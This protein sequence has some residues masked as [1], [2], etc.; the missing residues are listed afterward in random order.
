MYINDHMTKSGRGF[1]IFH[2]I[3]TS[4]SKSWM[5]QRV[6]TAYQ[7]VVDPVGVVVVQSASQVCADFQPVHKRLLVIQ[8]NSLYVG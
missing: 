8:V 4:C 1:K 3:S 2:N 6:Q 5:Y 7:S